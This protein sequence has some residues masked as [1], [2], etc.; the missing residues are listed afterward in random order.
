[1][2]KKV[3]S[4]AAV[5]S[6]VVSITG[7][8]HAE[9]K[10][11]ALMPFTGDLQAYGP[12]CYTGVQLAV[13]EVNV[14]GG[15]MGETVKLLKADTQTAS[16]PAIDAAKKLISV[17][18]VAGIVGALASG[19][20]IPVG[21]SVAAVEG[22]PIVS[23]ASTS[24]EITGL[25]DNDF[26]F[27]TVPTDAVQGIALANIVLEQGVKKVAIIYRN[28]DYGVGL[29]D[30]F[31][32]AFSASGGNVTSSLA[33]EK[34][35]ASYRAELNRLAQSGAERL[36][37]IG[38]PE[39]GNTIV[40]QALEEG[41]FDKFIFTDGMQSQNVIDTVGAE[42]L[43]GAFG[44]SPAAQESVARDT[45]R[46]AFEANFGKLPNEP[47]IDTAYDAAMLL[48]LGIE[49]SGSTEGAKVRDAMR[50]F[51]DGSGEKVGPGE[52]SKAVKLIRAGKNVDYVGASGP[53]DFDAQGDVAGT[54]AHWV[55][56]G[57]NIVTKKVFAPEM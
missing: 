21:L 12:Q 44:T 51:A 19:N 9:V 31:S 18:R 8:V 54:Y 26:V 4:L 2:I 56:E 49:K 50:T 46:S 47:F 6:F 16:Q 45:F 3:S 15:I 40:R 48:M 23:N 5:I 52:W 13:K 55:Y 35:Q 39:N 22:T 17:D 10:I 25:K 41:F 29:N 43:E 57:G 37:V 38:F 28:D 36:L 33:Y 34:G 14:A 24:P 42:S 7:S 11:G 20:T 53:V 27:R 1:M 30:A 32:K